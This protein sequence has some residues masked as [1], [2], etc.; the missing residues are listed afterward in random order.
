M[1]NSPQFVVIN[2]GSFRINSANDVP[3]AAIVLQ[4]DRD[5]H[6]VAAWR[7][8][9]RNCDQDHF[10]GVVDARNSNFGSFFQSQ[11]VLDNFCDSSPRRRLEPI[12]TEVSWEDIIIV[13]EQ[14][15]AQDVKMAFLADCKCD[16]VKEEYL[17]K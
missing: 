10:G 4:L 3:V 7:G 11:E 16:G 14:L 17:I 6:R 12:A 15:S 2:E 9:V 13:E 8:S 1:R 5:V